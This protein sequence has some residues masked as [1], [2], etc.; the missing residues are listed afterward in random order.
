MPGGI[1]PLPVLPSSPSRQPTG[2]PRHQQLSSKQQQGLQTMLSQQ[3]PTASQ[4][5]GFSPLIARP[6]SDI[7]TCTQPA[8]ATTAPVSTITAFVGEEE[9]KETPKLDKK[10]GSGDRDNKQTQKRETI[11]IIQT[12]PKDEKKELQ[13]IT[14]YYEVS[15]RVIVIYNHFENYKFK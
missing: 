12:P 15:H 14:K 1:D 11:Q 6:A 10:P 4:Q 2:S 9:R 5:K 7:K 13:S 8:T 3:K